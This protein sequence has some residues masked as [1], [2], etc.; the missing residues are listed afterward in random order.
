M[1]FSLEL[2]G[3]LALG[4][5]KNREKA[6]VALA[7]VL[8]GS[9]I[10]SLLDS[11]AELQI[12]P[13]IDDESHFFPAQFSTTYPIVIQSQ[14]DWE[15]YY[16]P[17]NGTAQ[18]PYLIEGYNI[19][20]SSECLI[21]ENVTEYVEIRDCLFESTDQFQSAVRLLSIQNAIIEG[22]TIIGGREGVLISQ[23][24]TIA[25]KD[26]IIGDST[27]GLRL[28]SSNSCS[29]ERNSVFGHSS[30][31]ELSAT[32][33][34]AFSGNKWYRN[35]LRGIYIDND[36]EFNIFTQNS[37][38]WNGYGDEPISAIDN[39][40]NNTWTANGWTD[41]DLSGPYNITG[42]TNPQDLEPFRLV[43]TEAP[44]TN[45]PEDIIMGEGSEVSVNWTPQDDFPFMFTLQIGAVV[46]REG[47]WTERSFS[48]DLQS[49]EPGDY[50]LILV[51][52][53]GSGNR[54]EDYVTASVLF[55]ILGDI[56]TEL[57]ALA[58]VLTL[59]LFIV[60]V[61]IFKFRP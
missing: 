13:S 22:S 2:V 44:I 50:T 30:G 47:L 9:G 8:L 27:V 52:I 10:N 38:G 14:S 34:S 54:T 4:C 37:L 60:L 3:D 59:V 46:Q 51:L 49:F 40:A 53:D 17:G 61:C 7:L 24:D 29:V 26:S 28:I 19:T 41:Y 21:I 36:S 16:F 20:R 57:V 58:S 18:N 6:L 5:R 25:V 55:V 45:A 33:H 39:G 42:A 23:C 15:R 11:P 48:I 35:S 1:V 12:N 32:N 31:L 56:G 43:D